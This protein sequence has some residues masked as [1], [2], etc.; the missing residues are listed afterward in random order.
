MHKSLS[1]ILALVFCLPCYGSEEA[2]ASTTANI[3]LYCPIPDSHKSWLSKFRGTEVR[4]TLENGKTRRIWKA[5]VKTSKWGAIGQVQAKLGL[6][7]NGHLNEET[8]EKIKKFQEEQGLEVSS[9]IDSQTWKKLFDE[10]PYPDYQQRAFDLT[11]ALESTDYDVMQVNFGTRDTSGL[12]WGPLGMTLKTGE[13]QAILK[14]CYEEDRQAMIELAGSQSSTLEEMFKRTK[15]SSMTYVRNKVRSSSTRKALIESFSKL[16][17]SSMVRKH[18]N[19]VA[20][21]SV[22]I[23]MKRWESFLEGEQEVTALDWALYWDISTQAGYRSSYRASSGSR[24]RGHRRR[25][26]WADKMANQL[27]R[28]RADRKKRNSI[29]LEERSAIAA[30]YGVTQDERIEAPFL[31]LLQSRNILTRSREEVIK[32]ETPQVNTE[33]LN[34][35]SQIPLPERKPS[36]SSSEEESPVAEVVESD[37][38]EEQMDS[39]IQD[40]LLSPF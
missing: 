2:S 14:A 9:C 6:E 26:I 19:K 32:D 25:K 12:T 3:H 5:L 17:S 18:Y 36:V 23:K 28:W 27:G 8:V 39:D 15:R 16:A 30:S 40:Y 29:F 37:P 4:E 24:Y 20:L 7:V 1:L 34:P 21:D 13:I 35:Q 22:Y 10:V 33:D 38:L 31:G 11:Y